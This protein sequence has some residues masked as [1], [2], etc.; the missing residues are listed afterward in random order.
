MKQRILSII[1]ALS[2]ITIVA[3]AQSITVDYYGTFVGT[4]RVIVSIEDAKDITALQMNLSLPEGFTLKENSGDYG[5]ERGGATT[6]HE[7]SVN[8]L[9]SGDYLIIFYSLGQTTLSNGTLLSFPLTVADGAQDGEMRLHTIRT[10]SVDAVSQMCNNVV[11]PMTALPVRNI[12]VTQ[13]TATLAVGDTLTLTSIALP[14]G[15]TNQERTWSSSDKNIATVDSNGLVTAIAEGVVD[16]VVE[17]GGKSDTC[18]VT[19]KPGYTPADVNNDGLIAVDDVVLTINGALGITA[20]NFLFAA[21]DMNAD[22]QILVDDVVQVINSVL[23]ISTANVLTTRNMMQESLNVAD[24]EAGFN[25]NVTNAANYVA[26]QFDMTLPE[27][28]SLDDIQVT[29]ESNH[30]V[31]FRLMDDGVVRV[32]VTSLT[33]ELFQG[34]QLLS[35]S[36]SA[37]EA[38]TINLTNACVVTR[39]GALVSVADA[40]ITRTGATG[41]HGIEKNATSTNIYDLCGRLVRENVTST[42]GLQKG[43]YLMNGKKVVVK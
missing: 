3:T 8:P 27:G 16:I 2:L 25:M 20:D 38:A 35:V 12:V 42:E 40:E 9:A 4:N 28:V 36:V 10:S 34:D 30:A 13:E 17:A 39:G 14:K 31:A 26:M 23:G 7:M 41:I 15:A 11:V 37:D 24:T 18:M 21:A 5:I 6:Y 22:G 19:V 33:N 43:I 1:V 29:A 32:I